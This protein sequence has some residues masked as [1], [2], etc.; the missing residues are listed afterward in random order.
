[1]PISDLFRQNYLPLHPKLYR[2]AYAL[3]GN[4]QDAEDLLQETYCKLWDR[5]EALGEVQQPEAF[6]VAMLK[7]RCLDFLRSPRSREGVELTERHHAAVTQPSHEDA[8]ELRL[9]KQLIERLPE[10]QKQVL[11]LRGLADCSIQEIEKITGLTAV[12]IRTLL[13]RARRTLKEQYVKLT[14]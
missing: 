6:A 7:N 13:L 4:R 9:V 11:K 8:D 1:M 12:N 3:V 2:V 5:R 10:K 14:T